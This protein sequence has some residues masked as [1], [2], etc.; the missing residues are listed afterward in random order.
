MKPTIEGLS[1][2]DA[3]YSEKLAPFQDLGPKNGYR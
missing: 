1:K 2:D 3:L